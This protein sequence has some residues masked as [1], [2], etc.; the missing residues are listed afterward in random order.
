MTDYQYI[1]HIDYPL[2]QGVV[3]VFKS[4]ISNILLTTAKKKEYIRK[5]NCYN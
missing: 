3:I 5:N 4:I 1:E 2:S